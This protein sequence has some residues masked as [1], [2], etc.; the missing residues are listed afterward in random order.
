V[1]DLEKS[2]QF[3][4]VPLVEAKYPLQSIEDV[5]EVGQDIPPLHHAAYLVIA[6]Q[7]SDENFVPPIH[8]GEAPT[9]KPS[10]IP[11]KVSL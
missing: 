7:L 2:S 3:S 11:Q 6:S 4:N 10:K 1:S 5:H 9:R 8:H